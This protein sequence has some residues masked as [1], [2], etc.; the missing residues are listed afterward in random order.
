MINICVYCNPN[1]N[2]KERT[3]TILRQRDL[4]TQL[5]ILFESIKKNW[6]DFEYDF[7]CFHNKNIKWSNE[8]LDKVARY[9]DLNLIGVDE[10]DHVMVPWQNRITCFTYPLKR[11]GSHRLVLDCDMIALKNPKFNLEM[12]WQAMFGGTLIHERYINF[13]LQKYDFKLDH[14]LKDKLYKHGDVLFKQY[15]KDKTSWKLL[16]PYFNAGAVLIKEELTHKLVSF[17]KPTYELV[18]EEKLPINIRHISIQYTLCFSLLSIST[19][20]EPFEPG[21]NYLLKIGDVTKLGKEDITLIH[22]CG[23]DAEKLAEKYFHEYFEKLIK[24]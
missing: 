24:K 1:Y 9:D 17:W 7:Y 15:C 3:G 12:D 16:Y 10:Y 6:K 4:V 18:T 20:W 11:Y 23:V 2:Q 21:F 5:L 22:Y 19:K 8:D 14:I 13:M